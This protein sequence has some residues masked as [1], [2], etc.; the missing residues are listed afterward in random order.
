MPPSV[1]S[2]HGKARGS[3]HEEV[4]I[5]KEK[6]E[7]TLKEKGDLNQSKNKPP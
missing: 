6:E 5:R 3:G 2:C 4:K 7:I 1:R